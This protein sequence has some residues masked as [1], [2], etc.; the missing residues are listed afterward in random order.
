MKGTQGGPFTL[1]FGVQGGDN[2]QRPECVEPS[3]CVLANKHLPIKLGAWHKVEVFIRR[4]KT[5]SS[6]DGEFR[7]WLDDA[8]AGEALNINTGSRFEQ[9]NFLQAW[10]SPIPLPQTE[11]HRFDHVHLSQPNGTPPR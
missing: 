7:M 6:Q 8:V 1:G 4:S 3:S 2:G 10:D 9:F 5:A 11:W